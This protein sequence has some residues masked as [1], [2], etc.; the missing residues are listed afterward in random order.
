LMKKTALVLAAILMLIIAFTAGFLSEK[1]Q[2]RNDTEGKTAFS[3]FPRLLEEKKEPLKDHANAPG[4]GPSSAPNGAGGEGGGAL[5]ASSWGGGR[6]QPLM[7]A[8]YNS[9]AMG[10]FEKVNVSSLYEVDA[11][12]DEVLRRL[13]V[14]EAVSFTNNTDIPTSFIYLRAYSNAPTFARRGDNIRFRKVQ[15][16][17][18]PVEYELL[19]TIVEI[20]LKK[21]LGPRETARIYMEFSQ[22]V[23]SQPAQEDVISA[24]FSD[25]SA[26]QGA[27][28]KDYGIFGYCGEITTLGLWFPLVNRYV[29][30]EW[31]RE[32]ISRNGDAQNFDPAHF[33]VTIEV[34]SDTVVAGSG[35]RTEERS[36]QGR[37]RKKVT[38]LASSMR[39]CDL[40]MSRDFL[41]IEQA[42]EGVTVR[43]YYLKGHEEYGKRLLQDGVAA[44]RFFNR[45]FGLY[46]Y[47][48]LE[49]AESHLTNGAG[50]M[51]F[52]GLILVSSLFNSPKVNLGPLAL[53]FGRQDESFSKV[54]QQMFRTV[55][56]FVTAHEA[57]HQWWYS[58]V[59]S[60]SIKSPWIDEALANYS[61]VRYFE[62]VHG[63]QAYD[64]QYLMQ[65]RLPVL[66]GRFAG[67]EDKAL[68]LPSSMYSNGYQYVMVIYC[69]GPIFLTELRRLTGDDRFAA[70]LKEYYDR[71]SFRF[72]DDGSLLA[73]IKSG[74]SEK[75]RAIDDLC[76]RWITEEHLYE[77][78]P[79]HFINEV[80]KMSGHEIPPAIDLDQGL[81]RSFTNIM[82]GGSKGFRLGPAGKK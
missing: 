22:M 77:D 20:S 68:N 59:G 63:R 41:T 1:R 2:K 56:E 6:N 40:V 45:E 10:K 19:D 14:R 80:A 21:P 37:K 12:Y 13:K 23:P 54:F 71:Y 69:K 60:D 17:G 64:E 58:V 33:K 75:S 65:L 26:Q 16:N 72:A 36:L 67:I 35:I 25:L 55:E 57:A 48:E 44:L 81:L 11:E 34:G 49:I 9:R 73:I 32:P 24:S 62:G 18:S 66:F 42:E 30:G 50:G 79:G 82:R 53:I 29:D 31:S 27:D 74:S 8:N 61:A 51:E 38:F 47:S 70:S 43:C 52:P 5:T 76:R 3:S 39:E 28:Y 15:V 7:S 4:K 46:P 78:V